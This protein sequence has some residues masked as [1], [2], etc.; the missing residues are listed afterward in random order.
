MKIEFLTKYSRLG[1]SSRLRT[2]QHLDNIALRTRGVQTLFDDRYVDYLYRRNG[3]RWLIVAVAYVRRFVKLM[4]MDSHTSYVIEKELFPWCPWFIECMFLRRRKYIVDLDDAIFHNY[5]ESRNW[6]VRKLL[7]RKIDRV[8]RGAQ[9]VIA[10]NSYIA[11]RAKASGALK[12]VIIPTVVDLERY[13]IGTKREMDG[14]LSIGWIGT[15]STQ[16][17]VVAIKSALETVCANYRCKL[18]LVGAS[19]EI[20]MVFSGIEVV[21]APWSEATEVDL[22]REFDIGIMPLPDSPFERGKCGYKLIQYMAC[23]KP[24]VASP[25][26]VNVDIVE[27]SGCGFLASTNADW[28]AALS[29]L[30][31]DAQ[32]RKAM[33]ASGRLSVESK[34]SLEVGSKIYKDTIFQVLS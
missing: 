19:K 5:D 22:I 12:V 2:F 16:K 9:C 18:I 6:L 1:A 30:L 26:G 24:T 34:F 33:G 21:V 32:V 25:V 17:Y 29:R 23:A 28:V 10:G 4:L 31:E 20:E 11:N 7:G 3:G 14:A 15:P 13:A 8:M 27:K